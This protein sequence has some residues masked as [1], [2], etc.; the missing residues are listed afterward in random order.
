MLKI[1]SF[2]LG[3]QTITFPKQNKKEE[4]KVLRLSKTVKDTSVSVKFPYIQ[5]EMKMESVVWFWNRNLQI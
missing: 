2:F 4:K 3:M 5:R 1:K